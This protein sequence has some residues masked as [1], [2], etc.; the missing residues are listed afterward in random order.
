MNSTPVNTAPL[1]DATIF[2][3]AASAGLTIAASLLAAPAHDRVAAAQT[4]W[5]HGAWAHAD[6]SDGRFGD[7]ARVSLDDIAGLAASG[8]GP[9][10]VHLM[11]DDPILW[12]AR[13]PTV[14]RI[15]VQLHSD[16]DLPAVERAARTRAQQ[17]WW[18]VDTVFATGE[19][20]AE[21]LASGCHGST[22]DG[23]LVMLTPPGASGHNLDT[24]RLADVRVSRATVADVGVD[25]GV[26][27]GAF[28]AIARAGAT[29]AVCGRALFAERAGGESAPLLTTRPRQIRTDRTRK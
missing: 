27:P 1:V 23:I 14:H 18:A 5:D 12:C 11:V 21:F 25:G 3:A 15:T 29:Y 17:V 9:I 2:D 20:L 26:H 19:V 22:P 8:A 28:A 10:D 7:G 13:L 16:L 24:A 4:I 6:I